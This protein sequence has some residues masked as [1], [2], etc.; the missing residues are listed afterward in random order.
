[1]NWQFLSRLKL[2]FGWTVQ[3]ILSISLLFLSLQFSLISSF[4]FVLWSLSLVAV[5]FSFHPTIW[6]G[7]LYVSN[8]ERLPTLVDARWSAQLL[9]S[10]RL[11]QRRS[12][13]GLWVLLFTCLDTGV[14]AG[15]WPI[16]LPLFIHRSPLQ[17][18][19]NAFLWSRN[20]LLLFFYFLSKHTCLT[21]AW[22]C[23][24]SVCWSWKY[25]I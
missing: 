12:W 8:V 7:F 21:W 23:F 6:L 18:P 14:D 16:Q 10:W 25:E 2:A 15:S 9:G 3:A 4:L 24:I 1:M 17:Y 5:I 19:F 13:N 22:V 20:H 11:L